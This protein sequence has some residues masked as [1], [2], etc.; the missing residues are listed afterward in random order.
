MKIQLYYI[1]VLEYFVIIYS[2][3]ASLTRGIRCLML[4]AG[5]CRQ[6]VRHR[7]QS[8]I[9]IRTSTHA[10]QRSAVQLLVSVPV[11]HSGKLQSWKHANLA[12]S[13][14]GKMHQVTF[15]R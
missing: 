1:L 10:V 4:Y 5:C 12:E 11:T 8:A 14:F 6:P 15:V 9:L 3:F 7:L 2:T 13:A